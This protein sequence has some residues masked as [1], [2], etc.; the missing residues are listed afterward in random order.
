M[1]R[2][3]IYVKVVDGQ[4]CGP[5]VNVGS[6]DNIYFTRTKVSDNFALNYMSRV[7]LL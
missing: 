2:M 7:Y 6:G 5:A 1:T 4:R 3:R